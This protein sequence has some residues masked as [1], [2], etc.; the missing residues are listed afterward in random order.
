MG[1]EAQ[2]G[3]LESHRPVDSQ[4]CYLHSVIHTKHLL[5]SLFAKQAV[6]ARLKGVIKA[7][8][9]GC[10]CLAGGIPVIMRRQ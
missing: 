2:E 1:S 4:L 5:F 10:E 6:I 8:D 9:N 3:V 7:T